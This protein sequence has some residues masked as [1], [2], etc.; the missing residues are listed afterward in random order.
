[1]AEIDFTSMYPAV[2]INGNI[3]P[4]VPLPDGLKPASSVLGI[5]PLTLK[6]LY[7]K[8][9]LIKEKLL[10]FPEKSAPLAKSYTARASALKWLLVVCFGFLGIKMHDSGG[11]KP[12]KRLRAEEGKRC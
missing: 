5:V 8:R 11:S 3:S 1:V 4:E 12:M 2:I 10:H 7:E 6:P 9:V